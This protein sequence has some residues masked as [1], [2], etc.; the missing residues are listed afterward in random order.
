[1][2]DDEAARG[3]EST[4]VESTRVEADR[5]VVPDGTVVDHQQVVR[6]GSLPHDGRGDVATVLLDRCGPAEA[7]DRGARRVQRHRRA[8]TV[9]AVRAWVDARRD[10]TLGDD[11]EQDHLGRVWQ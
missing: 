9:R 1:V 8:H 4:R 7:G 6:P 5:V 3:V 11:L 2:V 10:G